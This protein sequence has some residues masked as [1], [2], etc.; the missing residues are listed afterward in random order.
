[1]GYFDK[2]FAELKGFLAKVCPENDVKETVHK[3]EISWPVGRRRTLVLEP[4]MAIELGHPRTESTSMLIWADYSDEIHDRRITVIGPDLS[5]APEKQ[6]PFGKVVLVGGKNF[7]PDNS[8]DRY[9]EMDSLRYKV[10]LQGYMMRAVSQYQREWSRVSKTAISQGFSLEI[11]GGV[12][13]DQLRKKQF[14]SSVEVIFVTSKKEDV[15]LLEK[16][17]KQAMQITSAMNKMAIEMSL[18]C[19]GCEFEEV[20]EDVAELKS[21]RKA[22]GSSGGKN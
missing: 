15:V 2:Q 12:L 11:L 20:C 3:N 17:S 13:I 18:D 9:K 8:Y 22:K 6:L 10:D 5:E 7:T 14:I 21:M 16:I 19:K 4:D 1:M